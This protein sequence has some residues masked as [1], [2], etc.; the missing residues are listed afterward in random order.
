[1]TPEG[2]D[3]ILLLG[4][5]MAGVALSP[6]VTFLGSVFFL[7]ALLQVAC[8]HRKAVCAVR[9]AAERGPA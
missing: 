9:R 8:L 2:F 1:M 3:S 7:L 5:I 6:T 4:C